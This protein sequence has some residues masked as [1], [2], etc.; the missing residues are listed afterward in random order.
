MPA[1]KFFVRLEFEQ[2]LQFFKHPLGSLS[3]EF[4][5]DEFLRS[6]N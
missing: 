2:I 5:R 1:G 6:Q 4:S 3:Q